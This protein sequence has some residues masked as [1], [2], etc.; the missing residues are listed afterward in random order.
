MLKAI[1][2]SALVAVALSLSGTALAQGYVDDAQDRFDEILMMTPHDNLIEARADV[3][4]PAG[5]ILLDNPG[6]ARALVLGCETACQNPRLRLRVAGMPDLVATGDPRSP[7]RVAL[8]IPEAYA[9]SLSNLEIELQLNCDRDHCAHRWAL[10]ARG[11]APALAQR[12]LP[13]AITDAQ[14]NAATDLRPQWSQRPNADDLRFYYPPRAW[15]DR[16]AGSARLQCLVAAGGAL[17]CRLNEEQPRGAYFGVAAARLATLLRVAEQ[18]ENGQSTVGRR[19][20]VPIVFQPAG[21]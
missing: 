16:V 19:V 12:G 7:R 5:P 8:E 13:A 9:R 15:R 2:A 1:Y 17:Q 3:R 21:S 6:N 20:T 11:P 18:D 14:W 4:P 10:L